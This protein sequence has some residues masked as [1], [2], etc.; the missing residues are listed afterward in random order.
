MSGVLEDEYMCVHPQEIFSNS[1][2]ILIMWLLPSPEWSGREAHPDSEGRGGVGLPGKGWKESFAV[3]SEANRRP[4]LKRR[5][6]GCSER[7][8]K[9]HA[10]AKETDGATWNYE[11]VLQFPVCRHSW[12]G[13]LWVDSIGRLLLNTCCLSL[14][15]STN[16]TVRKERKNF[17]L[18]VL[19][20]K[21]T[22]TLVIKLTLKVGSEV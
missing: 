18:A 13:P 14:S 9:V 10:R 11:T 1:W 6:S 16:I 4:L 7:A 8:G 12:G 17:L 22:N 20:S 19:F 2:S 3:W 21:Y 15:Q 5:G